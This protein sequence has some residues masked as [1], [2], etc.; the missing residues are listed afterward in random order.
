MYKRAK[1]SAWW[2]DLCVVEMLVPVFV[3]VCSLITA[4]TEGPHAVHTL[5]PSPRQAPPAGETPEEF[6][7]GPNE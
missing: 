7:G 3:T 5:G 2:V 1:W 6:C 4:G